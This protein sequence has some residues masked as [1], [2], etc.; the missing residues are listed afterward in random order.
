MKKIVSTVVA[1]ALA[2]AMATSAFAASGY[3]KAQLKERVAAEAA[4]YGA[5]EYVDEANSII[6]AL[7]EEQAAKIDPADVKSIVDEGQAALANANTQDEVLTVVQNAASR[8]QGVLTNAGASVEVGVSSVVLN[9][10]GTAVVTASI[11]VNGSTV[12]ATA[13]AA[14]QAP[15]WT[16]SSKKDTTAAG[17]NA[18]AS[19]SGV[20]KATG[21]NTTGAAVVAL[22]AACVL[23]TAAVKARK[24]GE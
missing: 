14:A 11:T 7:T 19:N 13:S 3:T 9:L 17:S 15:E 10:D 18:A 6:D 20:I 16:D 8:L 23:G 4:A 2:C 1:L 22:A 5:S 24:Q 12:T 21:L